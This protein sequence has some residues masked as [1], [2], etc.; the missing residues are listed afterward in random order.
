MVIVQFP[1]GTDWFRANWVFRQLAADTIAEFPGDEAL[2]FALKRAEA[3]GALFLNSLD[4]A[5][6]AK[7]LT[8]L[9]K[10]AR[11]TLSRAVEG[12]I[13]SRPD[14]AKGQEMY[15]ESMAELL[16]LID[17]QKADAARLSNP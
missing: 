3:V 12:W 17:R 14:D 2:A 15:L 7:L 1:N 6:A 8:A 4:E 13:A 5:T 16:E 10:V 9:E 11:D